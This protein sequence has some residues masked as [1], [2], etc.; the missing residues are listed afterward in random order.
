MQHLL[1]VDET[2][3]INFTQEYCLSI[4]FSLDG[5]S[6]CILDGLQNKYIYLFHKEL[7]GNPRFL[8]KKL[9]D[10]YSEFEILEANFKTTRIIYVSPGKINLIPD[11][12]FSEANAVDI[13]QINKELEPGEELYH[14]PVKKFRSILQLAVPKKVK[15]FLVDKHPGTIIQND[16]ATFLNQYEHKAGTLLLY[17]HLH[18]NMVT[19]FVLDE[20]VR[21]FNSFF[22]T[23]ENDLLYYI[24]NVNKTVLDASP[25]VL[26]NGRANKR[27]A[28][29][30][31]LRQ[32][33]KVVDI[34]GRTPEVYYS[35]LFDQL[36]DAR[37][38]NLLNTNP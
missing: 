28:I 24:L 3:D 15:D 23:N 31:R 13:Y 33:F 11:Q 17:I 18:K 21:F 36:P 10:I 35:Y 19:I 38:V 2:F 14:L 34:V 16:I 37:F 7:S 32:Y 6:F 8:I 1:L 9:D 20:S 5:F 4:Q 30:H 22:Y 26:L 25:Q 12:F 29:F 27:S